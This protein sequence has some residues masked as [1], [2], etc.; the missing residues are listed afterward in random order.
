M[1]GTGWKEKT[2]KR[3]MREAYLVANNQLL[4]DL[5]CTTTA[6]MRVR[7]RISFFSV[8]RLNSKQEIDSSISM[9][10]C[11]ILLCLTASIPYSLPSSLAHLTFGSLFNQPVNNAL[12]PSPTTSSLDNTSIRKLKL[13]LSSSTSSNHWILSL[14]FSFIS[15]LDVFSTFQSSLS[16]LPPSS[17]FLLV[18]DSTNQSTLSIPRSPHIGALRCQC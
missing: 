16:L 2:C 15:P 11:V 12:S 4:W 8:R 6:S 9:R 13:S 17:S 18:P 1:R 10:S 5:L 7:I 14:P 3:R